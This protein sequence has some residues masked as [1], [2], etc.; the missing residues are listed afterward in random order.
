MIQLWV[1]GVL[2][3]QMAAAQSGGAV[4]TDQRALG[5][6]RGWVLTN[7]KRW[8]HPSYQ[9]GIDEVCVFN[10]AAEPAEVQTLLEAG[11]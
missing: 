4:T 2:Q 7:D 6:E 5:S 9:G 11:R 3:G 8:G 1:D 10:R